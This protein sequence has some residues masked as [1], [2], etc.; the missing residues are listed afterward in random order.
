MCHPHRRPTF[1]WRVTNVTNLH[2]SSHLSF[3]WDRCPVFLVF[4]S[5]TWL[6]YNQPPSRCRR[7]DSY[8][9]R[10]VERNKWRWSNMLYPK[11]KKMNGMGGDSGQT[12]LSNKSI[13]TYQAA[14]WQA[15]RWELTSCFLYQ[16]KVPEFHSHLGGRRSSTSTRIEKIEDEKC[17]VSHF[18]CFHRVQKVP[19]PLPDEAS[20]LL[21]FH[22]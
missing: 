18:R 17:S 4:E 7:N 16:T 3:L 6:W 14:K 1:F 9:C 5:P 20:L 12:W 8:H 15:C 2:H 19:F 10:N 13:E 22:P 11:I 21:A